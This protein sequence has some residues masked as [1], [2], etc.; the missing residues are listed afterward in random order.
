MQQLIIILCITSIFKSNGGG[1][2][3]FFLILKAQGSQVRKGVLRFHVLIE[4]KQVQRMATA[5]VF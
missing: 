4:G 5:T 3:R 2:P 1:I